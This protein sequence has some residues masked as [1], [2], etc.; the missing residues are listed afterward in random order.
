M[1]LRENYC[2]SSSEFF[3][4]AQI[5]AI[6]ESTKGYSGADLHALATEAA[7]GPMREIRVRRDKLTPK[8]LTKRL[9]GH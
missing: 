7:M 6:V 1:F 2:E 4:M 8:F 9:S 5:A 3:S